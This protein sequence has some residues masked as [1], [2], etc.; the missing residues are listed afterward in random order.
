ME[1]V[2]GIAAVRSRI[3]QRSDDVEELDERARPAVGQD[4]RERWLLGRPHVK[5]VDVGAVDLGRELIEAVHARLARSPV[6]LVAPVRDEILEVAELGAVVPARAGELLRE[7]CPCEALMQV[8]EDRLRN[9]D[10]VRG[11]VAHAQYRRRKPSLMG[12]RFS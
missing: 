8:V 4:D 5:E 6:V 12:S 3:G 11:D 10:A 2:R 7:A 9:V 1:G